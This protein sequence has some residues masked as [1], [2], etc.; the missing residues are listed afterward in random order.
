MND[1]F[2]W[3]KVVIWVLFLSPFVIG[4][5]LSLWRKSNISKKENDEFMLM[6]DA[7]LQAVDY[8]SVIPNLKNGEWEELG[9]ERL[10]LISGREGENNIIQPES[11]K[12]I[13]KVCSELRRYRFRIGS[14]YEFAYLIT[15]HSDSRKWAYKLLQASGAISDMDVNE[16]EAYYTKKIKEIDD[17][18][19]ELLD[20]RISETYKGLS[21]ALAKI[22]EDLTGSG[23]SIG[24]IDQFIEEMNNPEFRQ[25]IYSYANDEGINTTEVQAYYAELVISQSQ[26]KEAELKRLKTHLN[27]LLQ[28]LNALMIQQKM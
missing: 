18:E 2:R 24:T 3:W 10:S 4:C 19:A 13:R 12:C 5:G 28:S 6:R 27:I 1:R 11:K 14:S 25:K 20:V 8:D 16:F 23:Y 26:T 7:M 9:R 15:K 22:Y 17:K 21:E